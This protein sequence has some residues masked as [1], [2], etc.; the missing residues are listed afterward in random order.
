MKR[1][2]SRII[3]KD[4]IRLKKQ[5]RR[6]TTISKIDEKRIRTILSEVKSIAKSR[7]YK[8]FA[9]IEIKIITL[10]S[11]RILTN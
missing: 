5:R 3:N 7:R 9:K 4:I 11:K 6:K 2:T 1:E 8:R 10:T